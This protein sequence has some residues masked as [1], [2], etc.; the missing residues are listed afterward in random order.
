MVDR[1]A[2]RLVEVGWGALAC[3]GQGKSFEANPILGSRL[4]NRLGLHPARVA[5]A[6]AMT[7]WR[8]SLLRQLM[9]ADLRARF[10]R[11]GFVAIEGFVGDVELA[12]IRRELGALAGAAREM[13]QGD[14][15]TQRVLLDAA[16]MRRTPALRRL[17]RGRHL[18]DLLSYASARW[19][20]PRMYVQRIR[21]GAA[22]SDPQTDLH[23]DTFHPTM[24]AWLYLEDVGDGDGPFEY[25]PGSHRL[26]RARLGW[27]RAA[28]LRWS[29]SGCRYSRRGSSRIAED[30]LAD[31]GLPP[32]RSIPGRAGTL[33][34]ANTHGFHRRG[35]A[36]PGA[37]RLELWAF[38]R[39]NPFSPFPGLGVMALGWIEDAVHQ[40]LLLRQDLAAARRG[41]PA[42]WRMIDRRDMLAAI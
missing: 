28:S 24:K 30:R 21:R 10:H 38:S 6:A 15:R 34:I 14:T 1:L 16:A 12:A 4:L 37:S 36:R 31:L 19:H 17:A 39:S 42:T 35:A 5:L 41:Q 22:R 3:L 29:E 23:A 8:W 26:T 27:E 18:L 32:P 7:R 9:P 40:W 11:D 13:T 20:P 25:V 2:R 33:I